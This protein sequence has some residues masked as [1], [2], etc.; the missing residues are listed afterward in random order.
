LIKKKNAF[1]ALL[2]SCYYEDFMVETLN[3]ETD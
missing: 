3:P 2:M 1:L